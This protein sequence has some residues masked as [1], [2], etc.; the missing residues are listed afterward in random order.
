MAK[1]TLDGNAFNTNGDLPAVGSAA[2]D[3]R[4]V[5]GKLNT[6]GLDEFSG[7]KIIMNIVP[8]LDTPTCATSTRKFN[9]EAEDLHGRDLARDPGA[10]SGAAEVQ[11][12]SAL[13]PLGAEA[14]VP[15]IGLEP[16]G[17]PHADAV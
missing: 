5:D 7:K 13:G 4:L 2:P 12:R 15:T 6:V 16:Y 8:S 17:D 10:P 9:E 3:F 14:F 1:V 11:E